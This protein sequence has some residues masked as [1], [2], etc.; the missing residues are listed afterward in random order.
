MDLIAGIPRALSWLDCV[1]GYRPIFDEV[2]QRVERSLGVETPRES[3]H[4]LRINAIAYSRLEAASETEDST[5][6]EES[7]KPECERFLDSEI[8]AIYW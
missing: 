1:D 2:T 6:I 7:D 4:D 3:V 5:S 8:I